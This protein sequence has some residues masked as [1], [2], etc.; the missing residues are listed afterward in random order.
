MKKVTIIYRNQNNPNA[1][2]FIKQNLEE[3]FGSYITF[4][5]CFLSK[6]NDN[7]ILNA[8]AFIALNGDV[9]QKIKAKGCVEDFHKIIN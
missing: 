6:L 8:D 7:E 9:F 1:V 2:E 5:N 3:I 4:D